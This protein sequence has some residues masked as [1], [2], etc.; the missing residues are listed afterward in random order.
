MPGYENVFKM[1]NLL[2]WFEFDGKNEV[3]IYELFKEQFNENFEFPFLFIVHCSL[4]KYMASSSLCVVVSRI[5]LIIIQWWK[6]CRKTLCM[7]VVGWIV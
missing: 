2:P 6:K 3:E 4:E 7:T 5:I 1:P